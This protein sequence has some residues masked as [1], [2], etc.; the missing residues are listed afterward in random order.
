MTSPMIALSLYASVVTLILG[1]TVFT[2]GSLKW[3][4]KYE[5]LDH[6]NDELID[7]YNALLAQ[8]NALVGKI[9]AKGGES[10][11]NGAPAPPPVKTTKLQF[12]QEEVMTM[13]RLCHPDKHGGDRAANDITARLLDLRKK[14]KP[15][16]KTK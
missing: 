4:R 15:R 10:F 8:W 3:R 1:Y 12:T 14:T 5:A 9:N 16:K 6:K 7:R 11:L 13:V 2:G